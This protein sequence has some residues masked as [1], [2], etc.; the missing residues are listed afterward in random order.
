MK[1]RKRVDTKME[2]KHHV[3]QEKNHRNHPI[4]P[5]Y[6]TKSKQVYQLAKKMTIISK[7]LAYIGMLLGIVSLYYFPYV[8]G[9]IGI[10]LGFI[11]MKL[12]EITLSSWA[13]AVCS[14]SI[15]LS[16]FVVP[17]L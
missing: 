17:I 11:S 13:I 5:S 4:S 1:R 15:I 3:S 6:L 12:G 16:V 14:L 9:A 8:L 2:T 7:A 10:I